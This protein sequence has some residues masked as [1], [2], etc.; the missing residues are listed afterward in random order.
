[1]T[2]RIQGKSLPELKKMADNSVE[3]IITDPP[4]DLSRTEIDEYQAEFERVCS[5]DILAFCPPENQWPA[6][7]YLFWVKPT[8]TKNFSKHYG[9]F[10]EMIALHQRGNTFNPQFWANMT[11]VFHDVL[12]GNRIHQYQKPYSLMERL[13]L[14]HTNEG[15]T[16]LDPF[17][18]SWTTIRAAERNNRKAIGIEVDPQWF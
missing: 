7:R 16:V 12:E 8:S 5:G 17:A 1:M 2:V 18:G 14:I 15:D 3:A 6:P 11:G 9:R 4:Y 13:V 10:V